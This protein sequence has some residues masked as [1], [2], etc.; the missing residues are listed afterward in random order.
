MDDFEKAARLE[1]FNLFHT[2]FLHNHE[3]YYK[4]GHGAG[5][6]RERYHSSR[7]AFICDFRL[8]YDSAYDFL[9]ERSAALTAFASQAGMED[10]LPTY[11]SRNIFITSEPFSNYVDR[12]DAA[13]AQSGFPADEQEEADFA[14]FLQR[15]SLAEKF[16][17]RQIM[18]KM[19]P[20]PSESP[21]PL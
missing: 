17:T 8:K 9:E 4:P 10:I 11:N 6:S 2:S 16:I 12:V 21:N 15:I 5:I 1:S 18:R 13:Y 20:V 3:R 7:A 14:F 19:S